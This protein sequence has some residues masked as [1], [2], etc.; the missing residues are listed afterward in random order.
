[1]PKGAAGVRIVFEVETLRTAT[2]A[3]VSRCGMVW[4]SDEVVTVPMMLANYLGRLKS[5]PVRRHLE[6]MSL[7]PQPGVSM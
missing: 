1:M 7:L 3:T 6:L 4:F 2:L 5:V